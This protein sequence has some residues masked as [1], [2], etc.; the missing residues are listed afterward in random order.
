MSERI[1]KARFWWAVLY[2]EN[3]IENWETAIGDIVQ[4]PYAYCKH[5]MDKDSKSEHRKDHIHLIIAF[6]NT[7]T[8]KHALEVFGLLSTEGKKAVNTCQAVVNVRNAYDYL[9]HD[10]DSCKKAHKELYPAEARISGNSFDIG[11]YEQVGLLERNAMCKELCN[12]I[13]EQGFYNFIDFYAYVITTY[14]D[15]N[16][17]DILK[18]YSGLF[19]RLCKGNYHKVLELE[20]ASKE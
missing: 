20:K 15:S 8:Y 12:A 14:E 10:T 11:A 2:P 6:T 18:S 19:E 5:T 9:I 7:T 17:F 1:N 4:L 13:L 16:Y 3:M